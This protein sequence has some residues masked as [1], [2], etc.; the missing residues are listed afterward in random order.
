MNRARTFCILLLVIV[1]ISSCDSR[2]DALRPIGAIEELPLAPSAAD[3]GS[4]SFEYNEWDVPER[5]I[6]ADHWPRAPFAAQVRV[7]D[8]QPS[9]SRV[10]VT[11]NA[12]E[13]GWVPNDWLTS[14]VMPLQRRE[15]EAAKNLRIK[16]DTF[17]GVDA[18]E[19]QRRLGAPLKVRKNYS[20]IDGDFETWVFD[21]TR[22]KE[23]FFIILKRDGTVCMGEYEGRRL[24]PKY[25]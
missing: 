21:E 8:R 6:G 10:E 17:V 2:Y 1:A 18:A 25:K 3:V 14:S 7:V 12:K 20:D 4:V 5:V 22:N 11:A 24:T 15:S 9:V 16:A 13:T 19:L 23:T